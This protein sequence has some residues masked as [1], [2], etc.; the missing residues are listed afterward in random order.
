MKF[1]TLS[2]LLIYNSGSWSGS[3]SCESNLA[4][5]LNEYEVHRLWLPSG[6]G[7][8]ECDK[9][10]N[11]ELSKEGTSER[12]EI[13]GF[14]VGIGQLYTKKGNNLLWVKS[15]AGGNT[16]ILYTFKVTESHIVPMKNGIFSSNMGVA[17]LHTTHAGNTEAVTR[18]HAYSA[19][20]CRVVTEELYILGESG[21]KSQGKSEVANECT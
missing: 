15:N 4:A 21:F 13:L 8:G 7:E 1:I 17:H 18:I 6:E 3:N 5:K 9:D 11:S 20:D 2:V 14:P 12:Y 19:N 10:G 16:T